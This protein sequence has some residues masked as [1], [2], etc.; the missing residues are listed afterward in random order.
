MPEVGVNETFAQQVDDFWHYGENRPLRSTRALIGQ[1]ILTAGCRQSAGSAGRFSTERDVSHRHLNVNAQPTDL[2]GE[3]LRWQ[4]ADEKMK[5]V[6]TQLIDMLNKGRFARRQDQQYITDN[7]KRL[8]Q[9]ERAY[10][11]AMQDLRNSGELAVPA[12]INLLVSQ[13]PEDVQYHDVLRRALADLGRSGLAPLLAATEMDPKTPALTTI[14]GALGDIG[15]PIS[16]PYLLA[17]IQNQD[18]P[19]G[20][21]DAAASAL[22]RLN[23]PANSNPGDLFYDSAEKFYYGSASIQPDPR[24]PVSFVWYWANGTLSSKQVPPQIF[25]DIMAMRSCERALRFAPAARS[26]RGFVA[27]IKHAADDRSSFRGD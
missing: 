18:A 11:L 9:G 17:L 23:V 20:V 13:T 4:S 1:K 15:Y 2:D 16:A 27:R 26:S 5:P 21:K 10:I 25:M 12:M 22:R 19:N 8:N 6:A 3:L 14:C 7:I 24:A